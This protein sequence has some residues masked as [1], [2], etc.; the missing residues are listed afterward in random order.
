MN[1]A[2]DGPAVLPIPASPGE[3]QAPRSDHHRLAYGARLHS[4]TWTWLPTLSMMLATLV[5]FIDRNTLALLAPSILR[6]TGLSA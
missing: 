5:S 6:D 4:T 2:A 1:G 3:A